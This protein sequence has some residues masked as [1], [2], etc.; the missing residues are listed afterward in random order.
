MIKLF[1]NSV[2]SSMAREIKSVEVF[3]IVQSRYSIQ[4]TK[5]V[6]VECENSKDLK[7]IDKIRDISAVDVEINLFQR[8]MDVIRNI[9]YRLGC[10]E[11]SVM[12]ASIILT[13]N[14]IENYA[15]IDDGYARKILPEILSNNKLLGM[16]GD[17]LSHVKHTGTVGLI[18]HLKTKGLLSSEESVLIADDLTESSFR[19]SSKLLDCLR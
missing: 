2:I 12:A 16:F 10:G 1:D 9:D 14:K 3:P 13:H 8:T 7:M 6:I 17:T 11:V 18:C 5:D 4:L 15:V 19:I